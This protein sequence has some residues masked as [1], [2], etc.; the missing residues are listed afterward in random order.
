MQTQ[1]G[2]KINVSPA[3]GRDIEREIGLVGSRAAIDAA[4]RAIMEKV[5]A[6]VRPFQ[7]NQSLVAGTN[8]AQEEKNRSSRG[9][10]GGGYSDSQYND[11]YQ[12]NQQQQQS[13]GQQQSAQ[14]QAQTQAQPNAQGPPGGEDM[15]AAYGG[16]QN[17]IA[18]WMSHWAQQGQQAGGQP[19]PGGQAPPG[20]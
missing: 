13:Y 17:Y 19:S 5:H 3:S 18:L 1:T 2:C 6:V 7:P 4:K 10:G 14:S 15:Y 20:S 16:Y 11:R 12:D 8:I 9:G